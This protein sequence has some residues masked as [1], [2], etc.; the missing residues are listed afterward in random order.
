MPR[1]LLLSLAPGLG[2]CDPNEQ[3]SQEGKAREQEVAS[4]GA[5]QRLQGG[6]ELDYEEGA[7]PVEGGS[8][9]GGG[10]LGLLGEELGC[11][12][13][14]QG[15]HAHGVR[16]GEGD[17]TGKRQPGQVR[18]DVIIVFLIVITLYILNNN[19]QVLSSSSRGRL[20]CGQWPIFVFSISF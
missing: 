19:K 1:D 18:C 9:R 20:G 2:H 12:D 3:S 15:P 4:A 6:R 11:H 17:D 5:D 16:H 8:Q 14:G 13:P 7:K 10:G